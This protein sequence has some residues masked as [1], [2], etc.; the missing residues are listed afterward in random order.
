MQDVLTIVYGTAVGFAM[1][2]LLATGHDA[3][4]Q[5]PLRF[6]MTDRGSTAH[7]LLGML[8]RVAA[9]PFLLARNA[10]EALRGQTGGIAMI[11]GLIAIA[12]MWGCL[13]GMVVLDIVGSVTTTAT[14]GR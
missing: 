3:V 9:G 12:C 2:G 14:A 11:A 7:L 6:A 13:S 4:T 5:R 10:Y 8:L 1:A